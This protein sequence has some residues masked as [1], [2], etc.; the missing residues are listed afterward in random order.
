MPVI[1]IHNL[2]KVYGN[3]VAVDSVTLT[4]ERG[5]V[6][7]FL[8]PN[9]AGKTTTVKMLLGLV[10]STSGRASILDH[11]PGD[12]RVMGRVGFLPEHFRFPS[13]M[14]ATGF[15]DIHGRLLGMSAS[16]RRQRGAELLAQVDLADRASTRLGDF[17]KGMSQRIGLA[18]AL[19]NEP[20]IVFLDEPTSGLDPLGRREVR[21]LI[22]GL[23]TAGVAV[24]LNS[25]LLSE[26]EAVCDRVAIVKR[27]RVVRLGSLHDLTRGNLEVNLRA[28]GLDADM[29][30]GL[31][32]WGKVVSSNVDRVTL[33]LEAE[34]TIPLVVE[35]LVGHGARI[36]ELSP[37][38]LSLEDLFARVMEEDLG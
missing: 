31:A 23:R 6:F 29:I 34:E 8:G 35:W 14:T 27:G 19:L 33:V 17:S 22:R 4:V 24:F 26:V 20:E 38:R 2:R 16:A 1:E 32:Q 3:T 21:D 15:L 7:G 36:F 28:H 10:H 25:H 11:T 5:E 9:G 12:P 13:W 18:Q 37:R 30:K